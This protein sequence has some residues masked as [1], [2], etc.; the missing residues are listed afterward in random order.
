[1][2]DTVYDTVDR[3]N[4]KT[5][6]EVPNGGCS[7]L[8]ARW[9]NPSGFFNPFDETFCNTRSVGYEFQVRSDS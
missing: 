2:F 8:V 5:Q 6:F 3:S 7:S 9:E 1:M 4:K